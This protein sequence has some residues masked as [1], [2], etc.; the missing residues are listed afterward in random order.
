[1]AMTVKQAMRAT[2]CKTQKQLAAYLGGIKRENVSMW[3]S[4]AI[5]PKHELR[6]RLNGSRKRA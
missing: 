5:P 3:G 6:I 4:G 2:G 1:M